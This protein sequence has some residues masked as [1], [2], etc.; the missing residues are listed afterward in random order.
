MPG[1]EGVVEQVIIPWNQA[2]V[3]MYEGITDGIDTQEELRVR[4]YDS[5]AETLARPAYDL[6]VPVTS[7]AN[8]GIFTSEILAASRQEAIACAARLV[9]TQAREMDEANGTETQMRLMMS[10]VQ[11]QTDPELRRRLAKTAAD[12]LATE[13]QNAE[14]RRI[15]LQAAEITSRRAEVVPVTE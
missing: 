9:A 10:R 14:D 12:K 15:L 5:L 2:A 13:F 7:T 11:L 8:D 1:P 4:F 6:M 3:E